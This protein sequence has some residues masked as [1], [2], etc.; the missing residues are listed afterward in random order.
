MLWV[1]YPNCQMREF[2]NVV[3]LSTDFQFVTFFF[4]I[5]F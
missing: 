5:H 1:G 4:V 2:C 3:Y